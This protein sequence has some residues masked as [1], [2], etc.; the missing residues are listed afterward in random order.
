MRIG[1]YIECEGIEGKV[2]DILVRETHI[3]LTDDQLVIVPNSM[4]LKNP[5][6]ILT[7]R[8]Q[9]RTTIICGVGYGEDV[10]AARDVIKDAAKDCPGVLTDSKPI[11]IFAQEFADSSINFE[12]TWWTGS[13]PLDVRKSR[14][15]V[16]AAVK[17]ALDEAGIE[18]P[19]PYR[20]LTF[21]DGVPVRLS[22][23]DCEPATGVSHDT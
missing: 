10:D 8:S 17:K 16:V 5:L 3:R 19:F 9:R 11:Q 13:S 21:N 15:A 2:E 18:I 22:G 14:D 23:A 4:L 7:D 12:V 1:D 20:T 6:R